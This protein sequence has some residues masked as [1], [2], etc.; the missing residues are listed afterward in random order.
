MVA[1]LSSGIGGEDP[2]EDE[3]PGE[4]RAPRSLHGWR[5]R[6]GLTPG[7]KALKS[8]TE[9]GSGRLPSLSSVSFREVRR[10]V[11]R[12]LR[13]SSSVLTAR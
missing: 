2:E 13:T 11:A 6:N 7:S 3:I 8:A 10:R 9:Q 4:H 1:T 12:E 5:T